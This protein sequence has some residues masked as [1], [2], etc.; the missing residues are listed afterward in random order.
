MTRV[1]LLCHARRR[2]RSQP[3]WDYA[4]RPERVAVEL[5][6]YEP[7]DPTPREA[8][9]CCEYVSLPERAR[10]LMCPVCGWS[11]CGLEAIDL[12]VPSSD[13][14]GKTLRDARES[15][16]AVGACD[17]TLLPH[18]VSSEERAQYAQT[19]DPDPDQREQTA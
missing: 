19:P 2:D 10:G 15:F 11:D 17:P 5:G 18:C 8:C 12:D 4:Y 7:P 6:T 16:R 9:P 3:N 13:N 1:R 14:G